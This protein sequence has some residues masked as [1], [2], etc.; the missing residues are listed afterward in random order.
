MNDVINLYKLHVLSKFIGEPLKI[1]MYKQTFS[2]SPKM[3]LKNNQGD[4]FPP[5]WIQHC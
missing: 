5:P 4:P 1:T 2:L 3:I